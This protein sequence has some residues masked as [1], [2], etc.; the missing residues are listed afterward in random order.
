MLFHVPSK[1]NS[2]KKSMKRA[3]KER[4]CLAVRSVLLFLILLIFIN[5]GR[6]QQDAE[7]KEIVKIDTLLV[8]VPVIASDKDG[9]NISGLKKENFSVFQDGKKQEI[10]FFADED[11]PMNVVILVDSSY[12]TSKILKDIKESARNFIKIFRTE[13]KGMIA[14][15][16]YKL[17]VLSEF[18]SDQNN[19]TKAIN[20]ISIAKKSGSAMQD[21]MFQIIMRHFV[22]V[23]G[24]KA[25]IVL[26]DGAVGGGI[27]SNQNL[28]D[29]LIASDTLIYPI[30]FKSGEDLSQYFRP[31]KTVT[32]V[33][34]K[35]MDGGELLK[36]IE[37]ANNRA[38]NF[39]KALGDLTGGKTF[40][41]DSADLKD[42]FQKIADELKKQY[43][44]GFY[45]QNF[46]DGKPHK[47][48]VKVNLE[49]ITIRTKKVIR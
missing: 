43:L 26:T 13:D 2:I 16:D 39:T 45:P 35:K 3:I 28:L 23:K 20:K 9:R 30:I 14:S 27:I 29:T 5:I 15:F 37:G 46:N 40:A 21:A 38:L 18:T 31:S 6:A 25:I 42:A 19:L 17:K 22:Q 24:R 1:Y 34:G 48:E 10:E 7:D 41:A 44:V 33:D 8:N 11:A 36:Q 32:M 49:D 4:K 12:S 47:I